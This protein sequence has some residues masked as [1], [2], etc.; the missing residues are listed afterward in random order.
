[1]NC[2]VLH[3][4]FSL[5][6]LCGGVGG[7]QS[8]SSVTERTRPA[9]W[10]EKSVLGL[11]TAR[12]EAVRSPGG[13][14]ASRATGLALPSS[15]PT[16]GGLQDKLCRATAAFT[17]ACAPPSLVSP[18]LSLSLRSQKEV[19]SAS[20]IRIPLPVSFQEKLTSLLPKRN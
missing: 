4:C 5:T 18:N 1:M 16:P 20:S 3:S 14:G 6:C 9:P 17:Q 15:P 7:R 12:S 11:F 19:E 10:R 2:K 8:A 13:S